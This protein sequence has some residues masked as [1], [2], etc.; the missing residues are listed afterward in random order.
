MDLLFSEN[1]QLHFTTREKIEHPKSPRILRVFRV[2]AASSFGETHAILFY[3]HRAMALGEFLYAER[4]KDGLWAGLM[5]ELSQIPV[6]E[7]P[8][9]DYRET[10]IQGIDL[11]RFAAFCVSGRF[12]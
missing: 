8:V 7:Y 2:Y 9:S 11:P 5:I 1:A 3:E 4:D 12:P 10:T 6:F